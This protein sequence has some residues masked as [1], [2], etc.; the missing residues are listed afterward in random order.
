[1]TIRDFVAGPAAHVRLID[2]TEI[3]PGAHTALNGGEVSLA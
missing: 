1:M 3:L 2:I